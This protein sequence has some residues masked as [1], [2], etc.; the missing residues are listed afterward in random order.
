MTARH[1]PDPGHGRGL[2]GPALCGRWA[3]YGTGDWAM[4]RQLA[5]GAIVDG[6]VDHYC[7]RCIRVVARAAGLPMPHAVRR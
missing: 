3:R 4:I 7:Q 2:S 6:D 5:I 1:V